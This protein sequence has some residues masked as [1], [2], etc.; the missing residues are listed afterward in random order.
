MINIIFHY[1]KTKINFRCSSLLDY[2]VSTSFFLFLMLALMTLHIPTG[3]YN[4]YSSAR[5]YA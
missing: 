2:I 1:M 5:E 4:S 3:V